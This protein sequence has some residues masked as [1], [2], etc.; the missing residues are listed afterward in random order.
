MFCIEPPVVSPQDE[1]I[2]ERSVAV[3]TMGPL[4]P[5]QASLDMYN[6]Y[7]KLACR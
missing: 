5:P 2:Y 3:M 1:R 7:A 6:Q 4:P